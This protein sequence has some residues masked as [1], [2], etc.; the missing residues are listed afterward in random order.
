MPYFMA[1]VNEYMPCSFNHNQLY[2]R[3]NIHNCTKFSCGYRPLPNS[4]I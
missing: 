4:P 1:I 3:T 2:H